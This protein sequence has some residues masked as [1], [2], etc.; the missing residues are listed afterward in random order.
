MYP[1]M[2]PYDCDCDT[3]LAMEANGVGVED[4]HQYARAVLPRREVRNLLRGLEPILERTSLAHAHAAGREPRSLTRQA[5][6]LEVK[7]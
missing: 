7:P 6:F 4:I 2:P 5:T 1:S 3:V